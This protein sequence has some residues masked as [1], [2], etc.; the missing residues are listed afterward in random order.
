MVRD[1][2]SGIRLKTVSDSLKAQVNVDVTTKRR[3]TS[4]TNYRP[5]PTAIPSLFFVA[6]EQA[7]TPSPRPSHD[8]D[9]CIH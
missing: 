5:S 9:T 6:D 1:R 7:T 3:S 2:I 4:E 8:K